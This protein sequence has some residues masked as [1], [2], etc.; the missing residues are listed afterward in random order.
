VLRSRAARSICISYVDVRVDL[1]TMTLELRKLTPGK[2]CFSRDGD[3][4]SAHEGFVL[5][6][7]DL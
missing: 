4:T 5:N 3:W 2:L 6:I 7:T 1:R